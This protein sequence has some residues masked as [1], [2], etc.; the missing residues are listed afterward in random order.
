MHN[1]LFHEGIGK[2]I[3]L[4]PFCKKT[5]LLLKASDYF[6]KQFDLFQ[7]YLPFAI[8]H[9][10]SSHARANIFIVADIKNLRSIETK[11]LRNI[12]PQHRSNFILFAQTQLRFTSFNLRITRYR[13]IQLRSH[14][15]PSQAFQFPELFDVFS[16]LFHALKVAK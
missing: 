4:S 6:L 9:I 7:K 16:Y 3:E 10:L 2:G 13:H 14:K 5:N 1:I 8:I 11:N 15:L 12:H